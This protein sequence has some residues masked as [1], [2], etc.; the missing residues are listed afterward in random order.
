M[1]CSTGLIIPISTVADEQ[2]GHCTLHLSSVRPH[3]SI[4]FEQVCLIHVFGKSKLVMHEPRPEILVL[5]A[6]KQR[7]FR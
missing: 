6:Y 1:F 2:L 7:R 5:M 3:F 4:H